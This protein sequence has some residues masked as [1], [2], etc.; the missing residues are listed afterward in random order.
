MKIIRAKH[1]GFCFGVKRA[2]Q[3]TLE[4]IENNENNSG[5]IYNCGQLIHNASVTDELARKGVNIIPSPDEAGINDTIIVRSHGEPKAFYKAAEKN[6]VKIV[7]ATC[8]FVSKIHQ[9]VSDAH[10]QGKI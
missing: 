4:S 6:G 2:I 8:P 5:N 3:K 1:S 9:L 7:D 10:N